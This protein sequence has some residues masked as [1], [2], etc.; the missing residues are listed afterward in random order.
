MRQALIEAQQGQRQAEQ[1]QREAEQERELERRRTQQTTLD[2]FLEACHVHISKPLTVQ[3]DKSLTTGGGVTNP[4]NRHYPQN[5]Q[6]WINFPETQAR[7]FHTVH[8]VFHP[9]SEPPARLFDPII[10]LEVLGPKLC[11]RPLA[12]EADLQ[13]Y[14]R[15]AVEQ[16]VTNIIAALRNGSLSGIIDVG[17][18]IIFESHSNSLSEKNEEVQQR[19]QQRQQRRQAEGQST[20]T[21]LRPTYTDQICVYNDTNGMRNPLF[22]IEYKPPHKLSVGDILWGLRGDMDIREVIER[23]TIPMDLTERSEHNSDE[24]MAAVLTQTFHYM[25]QCGLEYS[26]ITTGEAFVFLRIKEEDPTTL[27]YHITVPK[28]EADMHEDPMSRGLH[29]AVGQVLSFCLLSLQSQRRSKSWQARAY[30]LLEKWP[31]SR[32]FHE[33][34]QSERV[35]TPEAS[36]FMMKL[37]SLTPRSFG[38]RRRIGGKATCAKVEVVSKEDDSSDDSQD[39]HTPSKASRGL[40]KP[41]SSV[42]LAST[43]KPVSSQTGTQSQ[44]Y[45]TQACLLGL[46]RGYALDQN[47]PNVSSHPGTENGNRHAV[48][49]ERFKALVREQ[50]ATNLDQ[51]CEPLGKQGARGALFKI[52]LTSHG[53]TF[54][55][56]GTVSVFVPD[57]Q[58]EGRIYQ[59]LEAIQGEVVP[60]HLGNINLVRKYDL[61]LGVRI[62]H[63]LL[64]SWAGEVISDA[65]MANSK[66][67][68]VQLVDALRAQGVDHKDVRVPN[69]VWNLERCRP[70]LI[71]FE[72]SAIT[73]PD[74]N[75]VGVKAL[76]EISPNRQRKRLSPIKAFRGSESVQRGTSLM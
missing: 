58:H 42:S 37:R 38:L 28:E 26:Y 54:V 45:C 71:D 19:Y 6:Q 33:T 7:L 3:T 56:K 47:C 75:F 67:E 10:H 2:E 46:K 5:L 4:N 73:S 62:V 23:D 44:Q 76:Q 65:E 61:D 24:V 36:E 31:V 60:V 35:D 57:L 40:P 64:M 27:Y 53:Y 32:A 12:S 70:M 72:R 43:G 15:P 18:G 41:R 66:E 22:I 1:R 25:I 59:R 74:C 8:D 39:M 30:K 13:Y 69:I 48:G 34:P 51:D 49:I 17:N 68:V 20:E 9:H 14:Q 29:T 55:S 21:W 11:D 16:P 50:L 52:T 63:M